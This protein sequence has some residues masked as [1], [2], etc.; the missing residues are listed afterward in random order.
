MTYRFIAGLLVLCTAS[1]TAPMN[2]AMPQAREP[3]AGEAPSSGT[4]ALA[5]AAL[6][7][8]LPAAPEGYDVER[9]GIAQ[10]KVQHIEYASKTSGMTRG[11]V[12]YLPP[13]YAASSKYPVLYLLHGA[14]GDETRWTTTGA[15]GAILD[16]L[17]ADRKPMPMIV[18]M[19]YIFAPL[20]GAAAPAA[21]RGGGLS[22]AG[23]E[24]D[25]LTDLMPYIETH[26]PVLKGR[27]DRA[28]VGLSAGGA[29]ALNIG[30][31]HRGLFAGV[32]GLSPALTGGG[33]RGG[34]GGGSAVDMLVPDPAAA[35]SQL[36]LLWLSCGLQDGLLSASQSLH[37]GLDAR[38]VPHLWHTQAGQHE[39][40]VW[41]TDLYYLA[42]LLFRK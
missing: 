4:L 27:D 11:A 19:P 24:G 32:G 12:V 33:G 39:W 42:P 8:V 10:G 21:G 7:A 20:A 5:E 26:Y 16:N 1:C 37:T 31:T 9:P 22:T 35:R 34:R 40:P 41:K 30:L 38:S 3:T 18:V 23:F 28:L 15:A 13:G 2:S 36:R 25:L 29:L 6:P 17:Y 14:G